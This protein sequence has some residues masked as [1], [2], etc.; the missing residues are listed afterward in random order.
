MG[1]VGT[2]GGGGYS[3][4]ENFILYD[5]SDAESVEAARACN[6]D[7]GNVAAGAG[8][9]GYNFFF[10]ENERLQTLL[11]EQA[12]SPIFQWQQKIKEAFDPNGVGDGSYLSVE[13]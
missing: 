10:I 6:A 9:G 7:A 1:S 13:K 4:F 3:A 8:L 12:G 5:P 11:A 2:A